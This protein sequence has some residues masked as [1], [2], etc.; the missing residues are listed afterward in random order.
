[1]WLYYVGSIMLAI[2]LLYFDVA[3]PHKTELRN[4]YV[5]TWVLK[6]FSLERSSN[7]CP[8]GC[9]E[10]SDLWSKVTDMTTM[11]SNITTQTNNE[12]LKVMMKKPQI[13]KQGNWLQNYLKNLIK[14]SVGLY[15]YIQYKHVSLLLDDNGY[16]INSCSLEQVYKGHFIIYSV[17]RVWRYQ[18]GNQNPYIAEQTKQ[19][20]KD[21]KG[22]IRIHISQNRQNNGQKIPKG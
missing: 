17:R 18:R 21:T 10:I 7:V 3:W 20:P 8:F 15:I 22:V 1:M 6:W 19:W 4:P 9:K 11:S 16:V 5:L 13:L 14:T 2:I 12:I